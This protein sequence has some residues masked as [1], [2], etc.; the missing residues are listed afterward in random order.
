VA[1][2]EK[3]WQFALPIAAV[4]LELIA[5]ALATYYWF[6]LVG[7]QA[8]QDCFAVGYALGV[9]VSDSVL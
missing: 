1:L 9:W 7:G 3:A 2:S 5:L 6:G 4:L 8:A